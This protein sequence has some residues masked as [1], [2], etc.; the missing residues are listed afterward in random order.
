MMLHITPLTL[1]LQSKT[2]LT[3]TYP[4]RA[5]LSWPAVGQQFEH[6]YVAYATNSVAGDH[7][8]VIAQSAVPFIIDFQHF[9]S[10]AIGNL[11]M[12]A[13]SFSMAEVRGDGTVN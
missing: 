12:C 3:L 13:A 4:L 1:Y 10:F 6:P 9:T 7:A 5:D 2:G 8:A 11:N